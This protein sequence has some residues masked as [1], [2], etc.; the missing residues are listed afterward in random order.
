MQT[1]TLMLCSALVLALAAPAVAQNAAPQDTKTDHVAQAMRDRGEA[2]HRADDSKQDPQEQRTTNALNAEILDQ[3]DLAEMRD[4]ANQAAYAK[5]QAEY[6]D[7]LDRVEAE[8]MLI[9]QENARNQAR[10][11]AEQERYARARAD[12]EACT[13]GDRSRCTP[14]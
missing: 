4:R 7:E 5:A 9:E 8:R 6:Q 3:N 10:Y 11:Q 1:K 12:W 2:Y 14:Q 13:K